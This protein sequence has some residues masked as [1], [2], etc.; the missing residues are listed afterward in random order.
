MDQLITGYG[1]SKQQ[2]NGNAP[3]PGYQGG[4][5][6]LGD[7]VGSG[8][9]H[10]VKKQLTL[11][12]KQEMASR[13]EKEFGDTSPSKGGGA[14]SSSMS[15]S[16]IKTNKPNSAASK[17][18]LTDSLMDR[19]LADMNINAKS[20]SQFQQFTPQN[21]N[22]NMMNNT[23]NNNNKPPGGGFNQFNSQIR[24]NSMNSMMSNQQMGFFG[25]LALPA[26]PSANSTQTPNGMNMNSGLNSMK[27]MSMNMMSTGSGGQQVMAPTLIPPPPQ[28]A[29]RSPQQQATPGKK[30]ALDDLQDIFG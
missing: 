16:T 25:N 22:F 5:A 1:L 8:S 6:I 28:A 12:E 17:D 9:Q 26:P 24:P 13:L 15:L 27:P 4:N 10:Q 7:S 29:N 18:L 2:N 21:N 11:S 3:P 23:S 14:M 19:N 20:N 30:T